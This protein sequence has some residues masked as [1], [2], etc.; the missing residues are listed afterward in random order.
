[1]NAFRIVAFIVKGY[2]SYARIKLYYTS[3]VETYLGFRQRV[4]WYGPL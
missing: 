2:M 1:M 3:R 4:L